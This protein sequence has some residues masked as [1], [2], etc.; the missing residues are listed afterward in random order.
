MGQPQ[1]LLSP[2]AAMAR[3]RL[4]RT[5]TQQE[6][7]PR[8]ERR[9]PERGRRLLQRRTRRLQRL[10]SK[11]RRLSR[12]GLLLLQPRRPRRWR[13][14]RRLRRQRPPRRLRAVVMKSGGTQKR[15]P[16]TVRAAARRQL[17]LGS[18][19]A[20]QRRAGTELGASTR[21]HHTRTRL[22]GLT[23]ALLTAL[24]KAKPPSITDPGH[25]RCAA[26][27]LRAA[28][29]CKLSADADL[30]PNMQGGAQLACRRPTGA[31][32]GRG[33]LTGK[34]E[35]LKGPKTS[36]HA[37]LLIR[38]A[39]YSCYVS[40][41]LCRRHRDVLGAAAAAPAARGVKFTAP[42]SGAA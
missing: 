17:P 9:S 11:R 6:Q 3:R 7:R 16:K 33:R 15:S 23:R 1:T 39:K 14:R 21:R 27:R 38:K 22:S 20:P 41:P 35:A 37:S 18:S 32:R 4:L 30:A 25:S 24:P 29:T 19:S 40:L 13:R 12:Q 2:V 10:L 36:G 42:A 26:K 34:P 31:R 28:A 8:V 5:R